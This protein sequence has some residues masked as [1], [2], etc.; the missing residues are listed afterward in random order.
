MTKRARH[1]LELGAFF[2]AA[3]IV[4]DVVLIHIPEFEWAI[5]SVSF[6][7]VAV[8]IVSSVTCL[9]PL[10][11]RKVPLSSQK[12]NSLEYLTR[13]AEAAFQGNDHN[14]L[15]ILLD[16][17]KSLALG[18]T[19]VRTGLSKVEV[20]ELMEDEPES[21]RSMLNDDWMMS[22]LKNNYALSNDCD[23]DKFEEA[24]SRIEGMPS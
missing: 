11:S 20:R 19:A 1:L 23:K 10:Q 22:F 24:L 2:I 3:M 21:L 6:F 16:N 15:R 7:V 5:L 12:E 8:L 18:A 13:V 14:A 9:I 4:L 17:L